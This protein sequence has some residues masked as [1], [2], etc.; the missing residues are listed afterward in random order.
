[1]KKPVDLIIFIDDDNI[2]NYISATCIQKLFKP[3]LVETLLFDKPQEALQYL[4]EK[5]PISLKNTVIFLDINMPVLT[6]WQLLDELMQTQ[7]GSAKLFSLY[8][9]SSS[10][11]PSDIK[12]AKSH[13]LVDGFITKPLTKQLEK[14][15]V[16]STVNP[17][18][19]LLVNKFELV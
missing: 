6:G 18:S 15:F 17:S 5:E 10:I 1:M 12:K 9:L 7:A 13:P 3:A 19:I 16:Q 14:L 2:F 8:M 4:S 11:D